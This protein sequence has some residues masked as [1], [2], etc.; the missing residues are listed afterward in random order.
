ML[1]VGDEMN[2]EIKGTKYSVI[3]ER[4]ANKNTYIRIKEDL[5]IYVTTGYFTTKRDINKLISDN[6]A[7]IINMLNKRVNHNLSNE[8]FCY[9]GLVY[10][11]ILVPT[12]D[13]LTIDNNKIYVKSSDYLNKWYKKQTVLLFKQRLDYIYGIFSENIPYPKLKIRKMKTRWGVCNRR[14]TSITLNSNLM[15]YDI[16]KLDYVI[17]HELSHFIHFNHSS[18]FWSLVVKYCPDYKK[19]RKSLKD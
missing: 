10:D 12:I 14:N 11:I 18:N 15:N 13:N 16:S 1:M 17:I 19:I 4:K 2:Y 7:T 3:I 8:K 6:E 5:S 9:L